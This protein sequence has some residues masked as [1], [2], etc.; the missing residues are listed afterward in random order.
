MSKDITE[1]QI[2]EFNRKYFRNENSPRLDLRVNTVNIQ[3]DESF[4][5]QVDKKLRKL[6][7]SSSYSSD[8]LFISSWSI[9]NS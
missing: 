8:L 6:D 1:T 7:S 2:K 4:S 3:D 5:D 9:F